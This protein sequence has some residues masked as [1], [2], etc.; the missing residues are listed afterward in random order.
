MANV[1]TVNGFKPVGNLNGSQLVGAGVRKCY[2]QTG[3]AVAVAVGDIVKLQANTASVI[4]PCV[5]N[6]AAGN[7]PYGVVT[8]I[9]Y[10]PDN[11][12]RKHH[13]ASTGQYC[14]VDTD[15]NLIM[16][17]QNN[18][19]FEDGDIGA[20]GDLVDAGVDTTAGTSGME[21]N[22]STLANTSTLVFHCLGLVEREDNALGTNAKCLVCYN[23]HQ[24]RATGVTAVHG[25]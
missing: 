7:T 15:P 8:G 25:A 16:E 9:E 14:Y 12:G 21:I 19:S 6:A 11:L 4:V 10:D 5:V 20:N 1:D 3:V 13:P 17:V 18:A 24:F 2:I 23:I 22:T